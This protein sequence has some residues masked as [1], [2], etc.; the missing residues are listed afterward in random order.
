MKINNIRI[1]QKISL[2]FLLITTIYLTGLIL[3]IQDNETNYQFSAYKAIASD[4]SKLILKSNFHLKRFV[5]GE[6][7]EKNDLE[8]TV[9]SFRQ[10]LFLLDS[11]GVYRLGNI[12]FDIDP[13]T[14]ISRNGIAEIKKTWSSYTQN[15]NLILN[16]KTHL[17]STLAYYEKTDYGIFGEGDYIKKERRFSYVNP[18]VIQP[19]ININVLTENLYSLNESLFSDVLRNQ[20]VDLSRQYFKGIVFIILMLIGLIFG[21]LRIVIN[22][23]RPIQKLAKAA[24]K[25]SVGESIPPLFSKNND[26]VGK[27]TSTINLLSTDLEKMS[28]FAIN[29][30]KG[31]FETD[32]K[33]R[34]KK[35]KLGLALINMR[36]NLKK[37]A[38]EDSKRNW[39]NEGM[40]RF[41]EILQ[42]NKDDIDSL[43]YSIISGIVQYLN[44]N[45]GGIFIIEEEESNR[46]LKLSSAYAYN[47]KKYLDEK[48]DIDKGLLGQC[49]L[50]E[51]T[52][53]IKEIPDGYVSITSGLGE[54]TPSSLVI[55]PLKMNNTI[56]G[57]IEIA[58]FNNF[59]SYQIE[60]LEKL[61]E[62]ISSTLSA[63]SSSEKNQGLLEDA[64]HYTEQL[65]SQEEEMRQNLKEL[66]AT[67]EEMHS[68]Q[69][70]IKE[71]EYN[72]NALINNTKD[73]ILAIDKNYHIKVFNKTFFDSCIEK[74]INVYVGQ[75]VYETFPN[76]EK[77]FWKTHFERALKG[78]TFNVLENFKTTERLDETVLLDV[79]YEFN[80]NPIVNSSNGVEGVSVISR[81][82]TKLNPI[83]WDEYCE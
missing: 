17:D 8:R 51:N 20:Q 40:A 67:Q 48:I 27:L 26:E 52:I 63:V 9:K 59:E 29:I 68:I 45:Q 34:G 82:V 42:L 6:E 18:I 32:F 71:K 81:D 78:E 75:N 28:V 38:L 54:A 77:L 80:F 36:D 41:A 56:F 73:T 15:L 33:V 1:Q 72:L 4:N 37:V 58:S 69:K 24:K 14:G 83:R 64:Q 5:N 74:G 25:I 66:N 10:N 53:H 39:A 35:D 57:V 70:E 12:I 23:V 22:L 43:S 11:G 7:S 49:I 79:Y 47:K 44:A 2:F 3:G 55:V 46:Y 65:K 62:S 19:I 61:S 50:E 76:K 13:L 16:S 21:Y 31:A 60:F 30:G